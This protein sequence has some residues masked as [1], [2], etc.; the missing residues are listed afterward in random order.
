VVLLKVWIKEFKSV[1]K[2]LN[3]YQRA[4]KS[5]IKAREPFNIYDIIDI[6]IEKDI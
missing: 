5:H 3:K 4:K 1:N 2:A 6:I